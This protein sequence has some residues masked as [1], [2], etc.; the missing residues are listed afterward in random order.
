M[1][2]FT[3]ARRAYARS[4]PRLSSLGQATYTRISASWVMSEARCQSPQ[5]RY[6]VRRSRSWL[7]A[8]KAA[9]SSSFLRC[10]GP[11][12]ALT[13][14]CIVYE[15][16]PLRG[17]TDGKGHIDEPQRRDDAEVGEGA[18]RPWCRRPGGE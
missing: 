8:T 15:S 4:P 11:P 14:L 5:I 17:C 12:R 13:A 9:N 6:A 18:A 7:T 1:D 10:T 16:R 3:T 2:T